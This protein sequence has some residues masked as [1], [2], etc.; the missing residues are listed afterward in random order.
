MARP[1]V[2]SPDAGTS[3]TLAAFGGAGPIPGQ[4]LCPVTA[5]R[6]ASWPFPRV[7]MALLPIVLSTLRRVRFPSSALRFRCSG[8]T[9]HPPSR[10]PSTE[11]P[12]CR[13][14]LRRLRLQTRF[15]LLAFDEVGHGTVQYT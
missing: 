3:G 4:Y 14:S 13:G 11:V 7:R 15:G 10:G 9:G 8:A 2:L 12:G 5:S 1:R 6:G